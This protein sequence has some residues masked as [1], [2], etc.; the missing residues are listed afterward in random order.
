MLGWCPEVG[1]SN[2]VQQ[3]EARRRFIERHL[4]P[5]L[6]RRGDDG[7]CAQAPAFCV[8]EMRRGSL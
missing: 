3:D 2:N 1:E 7:W 6:N 8:P 4:L 5:A